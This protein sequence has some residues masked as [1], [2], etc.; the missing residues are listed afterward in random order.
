[1][2]GDDC[3]GRICKMW[4]YKISTEIWGSE[5][6]RTDT[7]VIGQNNTRLINVRCNIEGI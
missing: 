3:E 6:L 7:N 2:L 5:V 4:N 1:M